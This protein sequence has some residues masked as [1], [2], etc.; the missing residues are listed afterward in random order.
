M[1]SRMIKSRLFLVLLSMI[2]LVS[3][4]TACGT[5]GAQKDRNTSLV[6]DRNEVSHATKDKLPAAMEGMEVLDMSRLVTVDKIIVP[7]LKKRVIYVGE[8]HDNYAHHL[9]QLEIIKR[10]HRAHPDI[11]IGMEMF[12][13]PFQ[14]VLDAFIAGKLGERELLRESEWFERWRYDYRLYRPILD[15]AREHSIPLVALNVSTELKQRVSDVGF[16]GLTPKEQAEVPP[17]IDRSDLAYADRLRKVFHQH[18]ESE[19]RNFDRFIDVQLLWDEAM[20][21]TATLYLQ[22]YPERKLVVLAGTGHLMYGSGIPQRVER[23]LAEKGA[24]VIPGTDIKIEPG[25][26]DFVLFLQT[27]TLPKTGLIGI[28]ME[29]ADSGVLV[30]D[31]TL[32]GAGSSAGV[33]KGDIIIELNGKPVTSTSDI[34]IELMG[35][36]PGTPV[37]VKVLRKGMLWGEK[38]LDFAFDLG[39]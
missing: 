14:Q 32:E 21:E 26:A 7:L 33:E 23:R 38:R 25:I 20:A 30:A 34:R 11:A 17:E 18:P 6:D 16:D 2:L 15:Y 27:Q 24:I 9:N 4:L 31:L 19:K 13:Q 29:E 10:L 3:L 39:R 28:F 37:Q 8:T 36:P 1:S 5:V 12:Q 22:A 35:S